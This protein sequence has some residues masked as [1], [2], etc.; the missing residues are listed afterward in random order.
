[1]LLPFK[2]KKA[3]YPAYIKPDLAS[4][5]AAIDGS[6]RLFSDQVDLYLN[7]IGKQEVMNPF[8]RPVRSTTD[9]AVSRGFL[10]KIGIRQIIT[11][12]SRSAIDDQS[13][14]ETHRWNN[15]KNDAIIEALRTLISGCQIIQFADWTKTRNATDYWDGLFSDI[16][17]SLKKQDLEFLFHLGDTSMLPGF[18]VDEI[19]DIMGDYSAY[20]R[21]TLILDEQ[22]ADGLLK[23]VNAL[24]PTNKYQF[25]FNTLGVDVLLI[26]SGN[27]TVLFSGD[28]QFD[29]GGLMNNCDRFCFNAGYQ[30]G[31]LMHL[32]IP[33]CIVLG[34]AVSQACTKHTLNSEILLACLNALSTDSRPIDHTQ[35]HSLTQA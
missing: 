10:E 8:E 17:R 21:V 5:V 28:W 29:F 22:E 9:G 30:L 1:M 16:I 23:H 32:E 18:E 15:L 13:D 3:M 6:I 33:Q 25:L 35:I 12:Q 11:W 34:L 27:G 31:L 19:L 2:K 4:V 26:F 24:K 7:Q 14:I 20:G